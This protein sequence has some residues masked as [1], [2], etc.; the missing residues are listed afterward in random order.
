MKVAIQ[1]VQYAGNI[2]VESKKTWRLLLPPSFILSFPRK[3]TYHLQFI[4]TDAKEPIIIASR[5]NIFNSV[6]NLSLL[7]WVITAFIH[8][9]LFLGSR[10]LRTMQIKFEF[11]FFFDLEVGRQRFKRHDTSWASFAF[12]FCAGAFRCFEALSLVWRRADYC[13]FGCFRNN[14]HNRGGFIQHP[15][16]ACEPCV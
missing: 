16:I 12:V 15:M 8:T 7:F 4:N 13:Y 10:H 2:H 1:E 9:P 6:A 11:F 3:V 14:L 5:K